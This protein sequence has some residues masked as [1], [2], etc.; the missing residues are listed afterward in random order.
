MSLWIPKCYYMRNDQIR[1]IEM[2]VR[3]VYEDCKGDMSLLS[4][5]SEQTKAVGD[6][7]EDA[8]DEQIC[9]ALMMLG[10]SV[11]QMAIDEGRMVKG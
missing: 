10:Y 9:A 1:I 6:P 7:T 5:I 4:W 8:T 2:C 11:V 3:R